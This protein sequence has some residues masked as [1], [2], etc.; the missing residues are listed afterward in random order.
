MPTQRPRA[1]N[2]FKDSGHPLAGRIRTGVKTTEPLE[3]RPRISMQLPEIMIPTIEDY[4]KQMFS[5]SDPIG[6]RVYYCETGA[7]NTVDEQGRPISFIGGLFKT[8]EREVKRFLQFF[9]DQGKIHYLELDSEV[10]EDADRQ[11]LREEH[12]RGE[13]STSGATE[14]NEPDKQESEHGEQ[15]TPD[16]DRSGTGGTDA[17]D[18]QQSIG[19]TTIGSSSGNGND[20]QEPGR[21]EPSGEPSQEEPVAVE[22]ASTLSPLERLRAKAGT[23]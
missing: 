14:P 11:R 4:A 2:M 22:E 1:P 18:Q 8:D 23:S 19:G 10:K 12:E 3:R 15:A 5:E 16:T 17:G 13:G 7:F 21:E 20:Q 9:V 6:C